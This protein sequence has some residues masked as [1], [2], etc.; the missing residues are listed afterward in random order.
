[1]A[2]MVP[3]K[4]SEVELLKLLGSWQWESIARLLGCRSSAIASAD[5]ERLYAS[6]IDVELNL[7]PPD[8]QDSFVEGDLVAGA[9]SVAVYANRFV[10]GLFLF[11]KERL[12]PGLAEL[13]RSRAD[14]RGI[15][16]PWACVT[17][18]FVARLGSNSKLK[19]FEPGGLAARPAERMESP[20]AGI[21]EHRA[22]QSTGTVEGFGDDPGTPL[23]AARGDAIV[24]RIVPESDLNGAGLLYFARYVAIMNYGER[25]F[26]SKRLE[27]PFSTPLIACL[28]TERRRL[29]YFVN[30]DA[31][32]SVGVVVQARVLPP[33]PRV[34]R[35]ARIGLMRLLFRIDLY[36]V[37]DGVLMASSLV[38]KALN[39][40]ASDK[41]LLAEGERQRA[42][43]LLAQGVAGLVAS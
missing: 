22:V 33:L 40:P 31:S 6:F 14:L 19:V 36:R 38:R 5:G 21:A 32:D 11:G 42:A 16:R 24:Y 39:V 28:S 25:L 12:D 41:G 9:N 37:S 13:V 23:P 20:P 30:A 15:D 34:A 2:Q 4:L 7:P 26:L 27:R 8:S 10:E 17:N 18:A 3:D 29:Y 1:M 43:V 35:D